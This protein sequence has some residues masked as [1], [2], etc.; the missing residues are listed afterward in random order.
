MGTNSPKSRDYFITIN[1]SAKCYDNALEIVKD[2]NVRQYA[3]IV[4]DKDIDENGSLKAV[5]KH[6][7]VEL[8]NAIS[9]NSIRTKFE[10][11]HVEL[12]NQKKSAYQYLLHQSPNSKDKYQYTLDNIISN[13]IEL[14]RHIIEQENVE[15]FIE[16]RFLEYIAQGVRTRYSFVKRFGLMAYKTYWKVYVEMLDELNHDEEM[17]KDFQSIIFGRLDNEKYNCNDD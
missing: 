8:K 16:Q 4:H 17:I 9:F 2:L 15:T 11:A 6:I 12:I 3:F 13:D 1:Q 5:H 10:G 7:V 14:I